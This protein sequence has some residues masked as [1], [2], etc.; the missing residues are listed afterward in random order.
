[1]LLKKQEFSVGA[2][3]RGKRA[4]IC[5]DDGVYYL[6]SKIVDMRHDN[7]AGIESETLNTVFKEIHVSKDEL[8][9]VV[10]MVG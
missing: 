9:K 10:Q 4:S 7:A 2:V 1:M 5:C 8:I 6:T 3:I